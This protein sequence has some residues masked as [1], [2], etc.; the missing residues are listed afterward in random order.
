[1]SLNDKLREYRF[2]KSIETSLAPYSI[3]HNN[4][5]DSICSSIPQSLPEL[6][7]VNGIGPHKLREYGNDI[8]NICKGGEVTY[9]SV[10]SDVTFE[11]VVPN[12]VEPHIKLS[13]KQEKVLLLCD[14]GHNIFMSGPGGTGKSFLIQLIIHRY[15][16]IK[17]VQVCALTGC[18]A[19]LLGCNAKTIHSWSGT[20]A[21]RK[22]ID[23]II[24]SISCRKECIK[25]W[26]KVDILIV[27]EV[28]MMSL[29]YFEMLDKIG[30][31]I[32]NV[33]R[34]FGGIQLIFSG[35]FYQLPPV[36]DNSDITTSQFCFESPL[37][38]STFEHVV[39]LKHN[40]RQSDPV[41]MKILKQVRKGG[42]SRESH[43]ILNER[44][45]TKDTHIS[46]SMIPPMICP[47]KK[48]VTMVNDRYMNKLDSELVTYEQRIVKTDDFNTFITENQVTYEVN[49]LEK[50]M[51]AD[52]TLHLKI[53]ARVMCVA[54]LDMSGDQQI[55]N[56]SQG[57]VE[58]II[59]GIPL[60][61]FNNGVKKLMEYHSWMS[62]D[63]EG[64]GIQQI[65]LILAWAITIHKAQGVTLESAI[66]DAGDNIFEY[67]QTYVA[68]SRVKTLEGL[69]LHQFNYMKITTNPKVIDY[70]KQYQ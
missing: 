70:Y 59:G 8:I 39:I 64:L 24:M 27:D 32:R 41:F 1:M 45:I 29:K 44:I 46:K 68:L 4:V 47:L 67:G 25:A 23:T 5:I 3:F 10:K 49:Q 30:R 31:R 69:H 13:K 55:V 21:S 19:E 9:E 65:P 56:G 57:I 34:P 42:I 28:S 50:R 37:W 15:L 63:I 20:G 58:K 60:V 48:I 54:N 16:Q 6:L 38:K 2:N 14:K 17:H 33:D 7:L 52:K 62:D 12:E 22:S 11:S 26:R 36:G 66:I 51:N 43:A 35:D 18:A 61:H 40:F 53:G